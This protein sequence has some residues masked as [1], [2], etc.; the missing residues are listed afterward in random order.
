METGEAVQ[1]PLFHLSRILRM[2]SEGDD[3]IRM[4]SELNTPFED[5]LEAQFFHEKIKSSIDH[6]KKLTKELQNAMEKME[7][8]L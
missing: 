1:A 3:L 4:W 7:T 5:P 6:T 8:F 2:E